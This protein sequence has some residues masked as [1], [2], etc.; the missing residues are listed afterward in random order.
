MFY[1]K[2]ISAFNVALHLPSSSAP[3][4][5]FDGLP[6]LFSSFLYSANSL[7]FSS[8]FSLN[9]CSLFSKSASSLFFSNLKMFLICSTS[10][11]LIDSNY[12]RTCSL[13]CTVSLL[14]MLVSCK[15]F[16]FDTRS[17]FKSL[18]SSWDHSC[19]KLF[20]AFNI[21]LACFWLSRSCLIRLFLR[22]A[23]ASLSFISPSS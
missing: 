5:N 18:S 3:L 16:T 19:K 14:E 23:C 2:R 22:S 9:W 15:M 7:A 6:T 8:F 20:R 13:I 12:T 4:S 1:V 10:L 11:S 21:S 17:D